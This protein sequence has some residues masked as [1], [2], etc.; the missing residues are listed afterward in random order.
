VTPTPSEQDREWLEKMAEREGGA[1]VSAGGLAADLGMLAKPMTEEQEKAMRAATT[2]GGDYA[3]HSAG[4]VAWKNIWA[5]L[6]AARAETAAA[7]RRGA[8]DAA[9]IVER[10]FATCNDRDDIVCAG[11]NCETLI[12]SGIRSLAVETE[13]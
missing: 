7:Y 4:V 11:Q 1:Q 10:H 8:E 12:L 5:T 2:G 13:P 3:T 9:D 6:D